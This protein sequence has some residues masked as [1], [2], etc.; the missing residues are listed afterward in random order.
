MWQLKLQKVGDVHDIDSVS[1]E[2]V[3]IPV[4]LSILHAKNAWFEALQW[5]LSGCGRFDI[6]IERYR[7]R[8]HFTTRRHRACKITD[9]SQREISSFHVLMSQSRDL[10]D[11]LV[12][13]HQRL[14]TSANA[15][16]GPNEIAIA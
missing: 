3:V 4:V 10:A 13:E 8:S 9:Y 5:S 6:W 1:P 12:T 15:K 16:T 14:S 11:D 2:H 7:R